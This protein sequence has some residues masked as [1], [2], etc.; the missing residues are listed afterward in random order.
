MY[1]AEEG[2][3]YRKTS[4]F[5]LSQKEPL[6]IF[7]SEYSEPYP[8]WDGCWAAIYKYYAPNTTIKFSTS[9]FNHNKTDLP[10]LIYWKK[11]PQLFHPIDY[12]QLP[13]SGDFYVIK[14]TDKYHE[15]LAVIKDIQHELVH[16]NKLFEVYK[17]K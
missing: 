13:Q 15:D 7:I 8:W 5:L 10:F 14:K 9:S 17:I 12:Q 2:M 4:E 1:K 11:N 16:Q 6:S 3:Y